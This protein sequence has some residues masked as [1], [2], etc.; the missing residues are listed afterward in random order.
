MGTDEDKKEAAIQ[1]LYAYRDELL[2]QLDVLN[3]NLHVVNRSIELLSS[4][5]TRPA[6]LPGK[7]S[8][9]ACASG[10]LSVQKTRY[11]NLKGQAAVELF[12]EENPGRWFKA[13]VV[14]K[15]LLRRGLQRTSKSFTSG[16][17]LALDRAAK[18]GLAIKEKRSGV[19]KYRSKEEVEAKSPGT[20]Q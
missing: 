11:S 1:G 13:S 5:G 16:I 9:K 18:K 15:E 8:V 19:F 10:T 20:E 14:A 17:T 12:L 6:A 7:V 4:E 2:S 3:D